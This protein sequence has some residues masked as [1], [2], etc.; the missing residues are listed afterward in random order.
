MH[1]RRGILGAALVAGTA[2]HLSCGRIGYTLVSDSALGGNPPADAHVEGD[3]PAESA[4][5]SG[6]DAD[7]AACPPVVLGP[8]QAS[9]QPTSTPPTIDGTLTDWPCMVALPLGASTAQLDVYRDA[10]AT[11]PDR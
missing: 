11:S 3:A 10:G 7:S 5:D 4:P 6:P 8:N 1:G 9:A 2:L